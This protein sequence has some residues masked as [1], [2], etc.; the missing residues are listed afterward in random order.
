MAADAVRGGRTPGTHRGRTGS[1]G[2]RRGG[3]R[4]HLR[5]GG[6]MTTSDEATTHLLRVVGDAERTAGPAFLVTE[7]LAV[8]V[9]AVTGTASR[10][11]VEAVPGS[12][13]QRVEAAVVTDSD[14]GIALLTLVE[15]L[16]GTVPA[17]LVETQPTW[18]QRVEA[19]GFPGR[20]DTGV[21]ARPT[22][23]AADSAGGI[24]LDPEPGGYPLGDGF[25]GAAVR[26]ASGGVLGLIGARPAT[27]IPT[28]SLLT[29]VARLAERPELADLARPRAPFRG[30]AAYGESDGAVFPARRDE[31]AAVVELLR[32]HRWVS[33]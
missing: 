26:D 1:P 8:T 17:R 24:Q 20:K 28:R 15:R 7:T 23:R 22:L 11:V 32:D 27:L 30:L 16:P 19:L 12:P 9:P 33:I 2:G 4:R 14:H 31:S 25:A 21:W 18:G 3:H 6:H 5:A 13:D 29:A 10:V